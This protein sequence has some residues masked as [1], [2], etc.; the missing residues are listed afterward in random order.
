VGLGCELAI[1]ESVIVSALA[2][3]GGTRDSLGV[4]EHARAFVRAGEVFDWWFTAGRLLVPFYE[5][6]YSCLALEH[7]AATSPLYPLELYELPALDSAVYILCAPIPG[8]G[9]IVCPL[10]GSFDQDSVR[11]V[12]GALRCY[13]LRM[14]GVHCSSLPS[15]SSNASSDE[16]S[17]EDFHSLAVVFVVDVPAVEGVGAAPAVCSRGRGHPCGH[18][19]SSGHNHS[20]GHSVPCGA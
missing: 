4:Q 5:R 16:S 2:L 1:Y 10:P 13:D 17:A 9:T 19:C 15:T 3:E 11:F 8:R 14:A 20:C 12:E 7:L 6:L 18:P